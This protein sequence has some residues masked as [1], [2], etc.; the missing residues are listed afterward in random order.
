MNIKTARIETPETKEQ[1]EQ[2]QVMYEIPKKN[3]PVIFKGSLI[4][5]AIITTL[6]NCHLLNSPCEDVKL[7]SV[8]IELS[9]KFSSQKEEMDTQ[10]PVTDKRIK[11]PAKNSKYTSKIRIYQSRK[12]KMRK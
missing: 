1:R 5:L 11:Q 2:D 10:S 3:I 6:T 4:A 9:V 7:G 8:S 12:I